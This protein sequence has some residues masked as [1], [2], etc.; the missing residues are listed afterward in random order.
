MIRRLRRNPLTFGLFALAG[1]VVVYLT[2]FKTASRL[3][4]E[5]WYRQV[6][7][8]LVEDHAQVVPPRGRRLWGLYRPELPWDYARYYTIAESLGV[9]PGVASWYQSW[10][11]GSEH[12]FKDEA[13]TKAHRAGLL[14]M[15]TWEPWLSAFRHGAV[16]DPESSLVTVAEGRF[17]GFIRGW[18]R[19]VVRSR[20]PILIR[21][22]H[23]LGN[24]WYGWSSPHGNAPD[25]QIAAWRRI[26]DLFRE[27][28][29]RNAA[30]VWTPFDGL[31]TLAWPGREYVDWIGLDI[32]NYGTMAENGAWVGFRRLLEHQLE[33]VKKYGKPV[34][35]AEVGTS[36]HGGSS[37][38]W[39]RDMV[40][41][42]ADGA[43]P[44]IRAVVVFDNPAWTSTTGIPV[45]WGFTHSDGA[46][47]TMRP[48]MVRSGFA[49][50]ESP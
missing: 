31:D 14:P 44:E 9:R 11:D 50:A 40:R 29:A 30:F 8:R 32:F 13:V 47:R 6:E 41:A 25:I 10:G 26:V 33:P 22:M 34:I 28:G 12:E 43:F 3:G 35:L 27:E 18:A 16:L 49:P 1:L 48:G 46:L 24:P 21:P 15:V 2:V 45:D 20:R 36:S 5:L 23:E 38:D 42:L 17:D 4:K 39:W 19:E 7:C 37:T